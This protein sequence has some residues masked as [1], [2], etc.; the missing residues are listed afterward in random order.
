MTSTSTEPHRG[1]VWLVSSSATRPGEPG[2]NRPAVVVSD[3]RI[4]AGPSFEPIVVVPLSSSRTPSSLLSRSSEHRVVDRPSQALPRALRGV[5]RSRLL[6]RMGML[7]PA[8][9]PRSSAL[10][11]ILGLTQDSPRSPSVAKTPGWVTRHIGPLANVSRVLL[12][13]EGFQYLVSSRRFVA[14]E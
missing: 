14:A 1:E 6:R 8:K 7:P 2:K 13:A 3:D 9:S 11:L 4:I 5:G 10:A 12:I